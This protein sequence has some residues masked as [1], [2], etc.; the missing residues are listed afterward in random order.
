[1]SLAYDQPPTLPIPKYVKISRL[2]LGGTSGKEP[3][4]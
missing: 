2:I 1:M 3:A 4:C